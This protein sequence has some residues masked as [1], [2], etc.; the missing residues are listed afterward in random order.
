MRDFQHRSER[1]SF[2]IL[3]FES[4]K[5]SG[6]WSNGSRQ[7]MGHRQLIVN[8]LGNGSAKTHC[9]IKS[10]LTHAVAIGTLAGDRR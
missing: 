4:N 1:K 9:H 5:K 8:D 10:R 7:F 2:V 6:A 3:G